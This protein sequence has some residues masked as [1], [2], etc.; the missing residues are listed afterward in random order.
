MKTFHTF[1]TP[2][3][4]QKFL[5]TKYN[6]CHAQGGCLD[7]VTV[8]GIVYTMHEYDMDGKIIT[9]A[10]K[11]HEHMIELTTSN[12]YKNG[13]SDAEIITYNPSYLRSDI[14]FAQ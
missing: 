10:N 14:S 7:Y 12:R 3:L 9:W 6:T 13:Y 11:K 8:S 2:E 1:R 4:F 5:R